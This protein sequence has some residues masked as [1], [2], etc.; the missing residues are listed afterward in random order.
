MSELSGR[1]FVVF[2]EDM[3]NEQEFWY[4]R[5]R[6]LEAGA[7][8]VVAGTAAGTEYRSKAGL[9]A[10]SEAAFADL[11]PAEFDGV[12]IPGGFAPD[13]MRR[14]EAARTFVKDMDAG[15]KLVA[16]IC[17]AG[18]LPISAGIVKGRKVTSFPAIRDDM[19]NAGGEWLD[20]PVVVDR[21][22][23]TSRKPDDLPAFMKAVVAF[24]G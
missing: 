22:M 6:L 11:K 23:I 7:G 15:G 21:N 16:F 18:W 5:Y 4:P 17:H 12:V 19:V 24:F 14:S 8:V 1:K 20:A 2:V 13:Y 3:Y 10:R 9:A